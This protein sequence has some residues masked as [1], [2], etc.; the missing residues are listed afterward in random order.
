MA[1]AVQAPNKTSPERRPEPA[2]AAPT[3]D[4]LP[5]D[6]ATAMPHLLGTARARLA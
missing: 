1:A 6:E 3:P 4:S 2:S 5:N